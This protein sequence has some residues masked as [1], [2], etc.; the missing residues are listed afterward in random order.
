[1]LCGRPS[2][3]LG[4]AKT[5]TPRA[6]GQGKCSTNCPRNELGSQFGIAC[7]LSSS[8]PDHPIQPVNSH[9]HPS[10]ANVKCITDNR[11]AILQNQLRWIVFGKSYR[12]RRRAGCG[13]NSM[14]ALV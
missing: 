8:Q 5:A 12:R 3:A 6:D 1:A 11:R 9:E 2:P 4:L 13:E 10:G 7:C 14:T